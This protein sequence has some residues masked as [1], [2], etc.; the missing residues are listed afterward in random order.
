MYADSSAEDEQLEL[1]SCTGCWLTAEQS[2]DP[3]ERVALNA[4][5]PAPPEPG[6]IFSRNASPELSHETRES[7]ETAA[8]VLIAVG[9]ATNRTALRMDGYF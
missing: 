9:E 7:S 5:P 3:R 4:G 6:T 1:G 8:A 2:R